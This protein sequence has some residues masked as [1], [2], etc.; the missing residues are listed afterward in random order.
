MS[1]TITLA[2]LADMAFGTAGGGGPLV[3]GLLRGLLEHLH[4]PEA[5]GRAGEDERGVLEPSACAPRGKPGSLHQQGQPSHSSGPLGTAEPPAPGMAASK[6]WQMVQLTKRM[7]VAEEGMTKVMDMLQEMLTTIC[8][9][10]TTVEG[11]QEELQLLKDNFQKAGLE[12]ARE[13]SVQQDEHGHLLQSILD[14]LVEVHQELRRS[15]LCGVPAVKKL[16][17]QE[18][19]PK[20]SRELA[21]E[22][23]CR[24]SWLLEQHEAVGT[25]VSRCESQLQQNTDSGTLEDVAAQ[26]EKVPS[27]MRQLQD[28]GEKGRDFSREVLGQV[29]Q[30]QEQCTR[31][32]ETAGQL[33][34][35]TMNTQKAEKAV[36]ETKASQE[37][38]QQA[39]VQ[40][41]EMMQDLVQRMSLMEQDRQKAL[42]NFLSEMDSKLDCTVLAPLQAQ[43]EPVWKLTQ[44]CL[45]QGPCCGANHGAGFKRQLFD[46]VKCISCDRPLAETR[47][48]HLVTIQKDSQ[49]LQPQPASACGSNCPIQRLP[50][51]ESE[52]SGRASR[53][54]ASPAGPLPTSSSLITI[55]SCGHPA[56]F[57]C[58]NGEVDILGINRVVYKG[59]LSSP[60]ANRTVTM[61]KDFPATKTPQP[62]CRHT[63]E[64]IR[65]VPKYGSHYVSPYSCAATRTKTSSLGDRWQAGTGGSRTVGV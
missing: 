57:I 26:S 29:G 31:L 47:A 4:P 49:L 15:N 44:Q 21:R 45:C 61:D 22:A 13:Q 56:D 6:E 43:L 10:K 35:D 37:E 59:R 3:R 36:L 48:P 52:G 23:S 55:C 65:R 40:L 54:P 2:E 64:K 9:L 7:E 63:T 19:G 18:L 42:E 38:L 51:R 30:L 53:G 24:L 41:S 11:F 5:A 33:W 12:E 32:Q 16:S 34:C 8:S 20:P 14:Q 46:P 25:H 50:A 1:V 17:G 28:G 60:A 39:I 58:K 27:E 62:R